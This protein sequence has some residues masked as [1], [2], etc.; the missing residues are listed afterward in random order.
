[1]KKMKIATLVLL[2]ILTAG[3]CVIFAYGMTGHDIYRGIR[4]R[5]YD[6]ERGYANMHLVLEQEVPLDGIDSISISYHMNSNDVYLYEGEGNTLTIKEY[7]EADLDAN[8]LSTVTVKG[9]SLEI[10][11]KKRNYRN[12][13]LGFFAFGY[14][15]GYTEIWLPASYK[16]ELALATASGDIDSAMDI[17]LE[18]DFKA[19]SSGNISIP[20]INARN[21]SLE[22]SSGDV[23][24][25][26]VSTD[27]NI[28][29]ATSSGNIDVQQLTGKVRI[30]SSS[31]DINAGQLTGET[32][33][34]SSSG[35]VRSESISGNAQ[36]STTS[37][38]ITVGR[39]DG[40][41][42]IGASSGY[43][44]VYGG[45]GER[46]VRTTSGDILLEGVD[47]VW[48]AETSSGNVWVKAPM[49]NGGIESTSGDINLELG[50]L[51]GNLAIN[52]SSGYVR[53]R[54]SPDNAFD[55]EASTTSGD[56]RTFFDDDLSFSKKGN[57]AR[58]TY[59]NNADNNSIR[60]ETTSGDVQVAD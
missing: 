54:L 30:G 7:N 60:I 31:G 22:C 20:N 44:K 1:M 58:G 50:E 14:G 46:T 10:K 13:S 26:T 38:D 59:G 52:S 9:S 47:S 19:A 45:T 6:Y 25:E 35:C 17:T 29:I 51:T 12:F 2:C 55:F 57:N 48:S 18:K 21:I 27:G 28:S 36:I 8:E 32:D 33:I 49:G 24:V 56:I 16:G 43:V 37:G 34:N 39:I 5:N 11:G 42:T 41:A 40:T 23:Q 4:G 3:L 15:G 53:I